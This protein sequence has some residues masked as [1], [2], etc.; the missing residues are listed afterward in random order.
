MIGSTFWNIVQVN[1]KLPQISV[2][3]SQ[4]YEGLPGSLWQSE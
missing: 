4:D 1:I 3:D 2:Y